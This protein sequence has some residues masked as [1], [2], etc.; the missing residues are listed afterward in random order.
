L[1][2]NTKTL[3]DG[4]QTV[5]DDEVHAEAVL[6]FTVTGDRIRGDS[7]MFFSKRLAEVAKK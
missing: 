6:L 3:G 2:G 7:V 1:Y 5:D 4:T